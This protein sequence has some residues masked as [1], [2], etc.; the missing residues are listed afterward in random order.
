MSFPVSLHAVVEATMESKCLGKDT[1][2]YTNNSKGKKM[3]EKLIHKQAPDAS[4][5]QAC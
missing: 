5:N 4:E 2:G 3:F 1:R